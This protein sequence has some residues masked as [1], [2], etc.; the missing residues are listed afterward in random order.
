MKTIIKGRQT[1][2][3]TGLIY[4]SEATGYNIIAHNKTC[5]KQIESMAKDMG[6][7]IPRVLTI[8]EVKNPI[9]IDVSMERKFLLDDA[10]QIL[11][12]ALEK[13]LGVNIFVAA[14][15]NEQ[16]ELDKLRGKK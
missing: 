11:Q 3:T 10:E 16:M 6:C 5:A 14:I 4:T 9:D 2:K 1:G 15:N 12:D 8:E 13:Y 7:N